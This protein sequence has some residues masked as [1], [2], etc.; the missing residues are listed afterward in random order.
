M[1]EVPTWYERCEEQI[2][3][4]GRPSQIPRGRRRPHVSSI[5]W[6]AKGGYTVSTYQGKVMHER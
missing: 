4:G 5:T 1:A 3:Y 6:L 2:V